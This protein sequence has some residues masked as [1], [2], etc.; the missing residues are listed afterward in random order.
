MSKPTHDKL[1]EATADYLSSYIGKAVSIDSTIEQL[2]PIVNIEGLHELL[3]YYFLLTGKQLQ[4]EVTERGDVDLLA[5]ET[6]GIIDEHGTPVGVLD[7]VSLLPSRLRTID[8]ATRQQVKLLDGEIRGRVDWNET[9]KYRYSTGDIEGQRFACRKRQR[10]VDTAKNRVLIELLSIIKQ[11]LTRFDGKIA[12]NDNSKL[13]WFD[14][15]EDG[16]HPRR[17][18]QQELNNVY[19]SQLTAD[20]DPVDFRELAAVQQSR[21]PLYR[22]AA[23][24]LKNY[25]RLLR[26]DLHKKEIKRLLRLKLFAPPEGNDETSA[27]FELYWIFELLN[28][29]DHVQF[30][31]IT[32]ER[33]QIVAAWE[34]EGS[35]YL[36]FND[37]DGIHHWND[38][39]G[40]VDYLDI[41]WS[42]DEIHASSVEETSSNDFARRQYAVL[43][44]KHQLSDDIFGYEFDRKT[45]DIVLLQL[46]AD[47]KRHR[48]EGIFIGEVKWSVNNSY[49]KKGLEQLLEYGAHAK[50]GNDLSWAD[51]RS[52]P[53]IAEDPDII[54][55]SKFELGYFVGNANK[56]SGSSPSGI[57]ICGFGN[58]PERPLSSSNK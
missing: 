25:R 8:P 5:R 58:I 24:L 33:G 26:K 16:S 11:I 38:E 10:T 45:P 39:R 48:L 27:L 1:V 40:D 36:L 17:I 50:F 32:F 22:E 35:E 14:Q 4:P 19:L 55:S 2:D 34:H 54:G 9:M 15:W 13:G 6:G 7:F 56:I 29:F 43:K 53:H 49:L 23:I 41:S 42:L 18:I 20:E 46:D 3:E 12:P 21:N 52:G 51:G 28:Q 31:Q 57:Q 37:W 47:A 30:K 44:H